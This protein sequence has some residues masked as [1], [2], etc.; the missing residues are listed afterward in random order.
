MKVAEELERK[1]QKVEE[2]M[3]MTVGGGQEEEEENG[4]NRKA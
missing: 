2:G 4:K 1:G 3:A